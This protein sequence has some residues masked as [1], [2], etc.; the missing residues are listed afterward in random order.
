MK[1]KSILDDSNLRVRYVFVLQD[2]VP[3]RY[4]HCGL[5]DRKTGSKGNIYSWGVLACQK[6][7][8][9]NRCRGL[10]LSAF[11]SHLE[12][13][14]PTVYS[15]VY[16]KGVTSLVFLVKDLV[17]GEGCS[18]RTVVPPKGCFWCSIFDY[19][20]PFLSRTTLSSFV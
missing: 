15:S 18:I 5:N 12:V 2:C 8:V 19:R 6:R 1:Y 7:F 16:N 14:Q 20:F 11:P 13:R 3:C 9:P 4:R 17:Y 10:G